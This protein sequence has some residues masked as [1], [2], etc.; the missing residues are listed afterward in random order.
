MLDNQPIKFFRK[1]VYPSVM[2]EVANQILEAI[3]NDVFVPGE[4]LPSE[5]NLAD[6]MGV[7]RNTLREALNTLIEKGYLFRQR[8][9]GTFVSLQSGVMLKANLADVVGTTTLISNQKKVPGQIDFTFQYELPSKDIA[10][11]LQISESVEVMHVSRV[12]TA[13]GTPVIKSDEYFRSDIPGLDYDLSPFK[14]VDN[15]SIYDYFRKANYGIQTVI[16]HVHAIVADAEMANKLKVKENT[17]LLCLVQTHF[18]NTHSKPIMYCLNYH[19]DK[20]LNL[21]LVRSS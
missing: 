10:E 4:Q 14:K 9:V 1:I 17:P 2:D 3:R 15:W 19:N 16:T 20:I 5:P 21:M 8:G 11:S 13:D 18:S 7:S 6:Q 12:R